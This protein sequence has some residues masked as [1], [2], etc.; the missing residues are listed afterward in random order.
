MKKTSLV[1]TLLALLLLAGFQ[2]NA[3]AQILLGAHGGIHFDGTEV[4]IGPS[5]RF[6]LPFEINGTPIVG[7]PSIDFYPFA[8]GDADGIDGVDVSFLGVNFDLLYPVNL[9]VSAN[10]YVGAG[11]GFFRSSVDLGGFGDFSD[12]SLLI[13]LKGGATFGQPGSL[14]PFVELILSIGDG[15]GIIAKGGVLFSLGG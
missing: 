15:S 5:A 12:T 9:D 4:I 7:N 10:P 1:T 13:N 11:L 6:D 3:Q 14:Q 8:G 2:T